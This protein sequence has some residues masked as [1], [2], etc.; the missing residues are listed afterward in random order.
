MIVIIVIDKNNVIILVR[1]YIVYFK[2]SIASQNFT[3]IIIVVLKTIQFK[4]L[5]LLLSANM[6]SLLVM[7]SI[8][9]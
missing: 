4:I 1:S 5:N 3:T 8:F 6:S 7:L 9:R 2:Y